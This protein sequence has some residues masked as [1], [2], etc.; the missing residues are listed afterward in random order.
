MTIINISD[1]GI[2][3]VWREGDYAFKQQPA[4]L[5]TNE[6]YC[7]KRMFPSGY[8][9]VAKR[10]DKDLIRLE[11]I[12]DQEITDYD[13][14]WYHLNK[15]VLALEKAQIRHGDAT[16]KNVLVN[17]N[18]PW[19]IDFAESRLACDPRR[20]KRPYSDMY[21]LRKSFEQ[22]GIGSGFDYGVSLNV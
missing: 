16:A 11:W 20:D 21:W 2:S 5:T 19:L 1:N 15:L 18:K 6:I 3:K 17:K 13:L 14:L 9:P 7:L 22:Y 12:E 4:F 10:I 8:V